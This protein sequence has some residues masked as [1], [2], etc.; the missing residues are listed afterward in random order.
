MLSILFLLFRPP[1]QIFLMQ[2]SAS[3]NKLIAVFAIFLES[4]H[5]P[6]QTLL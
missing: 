4:P 3:E 6:N 1:K 2:E 5:F